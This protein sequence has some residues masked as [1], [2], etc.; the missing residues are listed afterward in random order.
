MANKDIEE[1]VGS[2][3][4]A[5][6]P[7]LSIPVDEQDNPLNYRIVRLRELVKKFAADHKQQSLELEKIESNLTALLLDLNEGPKTNSKKKEAK[8]SDKTKNS[9]D[10]DDVESEKS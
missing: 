5:L 2:I 8:K 9:P 10:S 6:N 3:R 4:K 7:E 1:F